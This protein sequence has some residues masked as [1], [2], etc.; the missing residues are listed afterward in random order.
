MKWS[1]R[2]FVV[3][4]ISFL[5]MTVPTQQVQAQDPVTEA[6]K[7]GIKKVIRA[8]DLQIQRFQNATIWLQNAQQTVENAMSKL[9]LQE[10]SDWVEKQRKLYADYFDELWKIKSA[11]AYY[12]RVKDIIENQAGM[13]RE[14]KQAWALFRQ[15]KN[16]TEEEINYM[17]GVYQGMLDESLKSIDQLFLVINAF[18]TQMSDAKRLEI[19]NSVSQNVS[20]NVMDLRE[21]NNENKMVSLQRGAEKGEIELVKRLYGIQ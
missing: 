8:L 12:Q 11:L 19:I 7:A 9:K 20:Q 17:G 4:S 21:F 1:K 14:Y 16:F 15:D 10:I 5:F 3:V 6:I 2:I 18:A 13:V